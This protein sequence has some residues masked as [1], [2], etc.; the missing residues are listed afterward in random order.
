MATCIA[1]FV[2]RDTVCSAVKLNVLLGGGGE[3]VKLVLGWRHNK[4]FLGM[5]FTTH[6]TFLGFLYNL[7]PCAR[8]SGT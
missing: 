4:A 6:N 2:T 3:V 5:S 8:N 7:F 1:T